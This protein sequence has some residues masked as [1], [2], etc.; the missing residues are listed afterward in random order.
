MIV[1]SHMHY[2]DDKAEYY[3]PPVYNT[4]VYFFCLHIQKPPYAIL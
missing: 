3:F 1:L 4:I 2:N